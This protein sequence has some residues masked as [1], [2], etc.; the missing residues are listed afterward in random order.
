MNNTKKITYVFLQGR[1]Q[2]INSGKKI[3]KE[4]FLYLFLC[5]KKLYKRRNC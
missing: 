2:R 4:F 3:S 1:K 5:S